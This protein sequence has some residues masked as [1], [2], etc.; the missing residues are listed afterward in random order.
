[1]K[2]KDIVLLEQAYQT[3]WEQEMSPQVAAQ[4]GV[5]RP[6]VAAQ[7][8][9]NRPQ[10]AAQPSVNKLQIEQDTSADRGLGDKA[11]RVYVAGKDMG[12]VVEYQGTVT[13][14]NGYDPTQPNSDINNVL[15]TRFKYPKANNKD[16]SDLNHKQFKGMGGFKAAIANRV[17]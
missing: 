10:V 17:K 15:S 14:F 11:Y 16:W 6:Q 2:N 4:P 8:S 7:P 9:V 3:I 1:M 13:F 12:A 5:N